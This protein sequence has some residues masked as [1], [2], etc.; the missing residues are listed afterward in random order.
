MT[1]T[2]PLPILGKSAD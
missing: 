1:L 2:D